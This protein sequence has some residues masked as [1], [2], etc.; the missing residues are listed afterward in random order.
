MECWDDQLVGD[1]VECRGAVKRKLRKSQQSDCDWLSYWKAS[2]SHNP[3]D[4]EDPLAIVD[5]NK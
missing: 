4:T 2:P 1:K 3:E 5:V